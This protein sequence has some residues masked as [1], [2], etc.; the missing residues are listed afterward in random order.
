MFVTNSDNIKGDITSL[1]VFRFRDRSAS[2]NRQ[3]AEPT[4]KPALG[5]TI[6]CISGF[7][8]SVLAEGKGQLKRGALFARA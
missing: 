8:G 6:K 1:S 7:A 4:T 2:Q 5:K 3:A